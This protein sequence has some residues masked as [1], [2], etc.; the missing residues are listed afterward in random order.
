MKYI[1]AELILTVRRVVFMSYVNT[2]ISV[3]IAISITTI[4]NIITTIITIIWIYIM[5]LHGRVT[6]LAQA[7]FQHCRPLYF[8]YFSRHCVCTRLFYI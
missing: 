6:F 1:C 3:N 8:I 4:L 2:T 5:G 7:F